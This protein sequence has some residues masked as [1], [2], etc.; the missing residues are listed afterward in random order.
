MAIAIDDAKWKRASTDIWGSQ[1]NRGS[2]AS[3]S[4]TAEYPRQPP[5]LG[6]QG[7]HS[8]CASDAIEEQSRHLDGRRD[9]D[10]EQIAQRWR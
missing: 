8:S 1:M 7:A 10:C 6:N 9:W 3:L 5:F 4:D 2:E